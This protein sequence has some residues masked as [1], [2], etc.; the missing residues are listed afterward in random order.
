MEGGREKKK[1]G[2]DGTETKIIHAHMRS[3]PLEP[4]RGSAVSQSISS[5]NQSVNCSFHKEKRGRE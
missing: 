5:L 4:K 3:V 1:E 2:L